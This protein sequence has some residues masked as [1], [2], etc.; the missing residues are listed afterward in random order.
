LNELSTKPREKLN[1]LTYSLL[2]NELSTKPRE[3]LNDLTYS[4][5]GQGSEYA[6]LRSTVEFSE[7][8]HISELHISNEED[9]FKN[10]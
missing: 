2:L 5:L 1:D 6:R 7:K 10:T 4:L 8:R 9:L 3:K